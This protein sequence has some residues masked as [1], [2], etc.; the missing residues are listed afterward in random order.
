MSLKQVGY[1]HSKSIKK[2]GEGTE[3]GSLVDLLIETE[4]GHC[5]C[6]GDS[7]NWDMEVVKFVRW[8]EHRSG[9]GVR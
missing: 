2:R 4:A 9:V 5:M 1:I 7:K 6:H 3:G 8:V